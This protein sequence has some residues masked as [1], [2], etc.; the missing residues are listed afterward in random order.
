MEKKESKSNKWSDY[1]EE[2]YQECKLH[3][4]HSKVEKNV[5]I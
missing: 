4:R 1:E 2:V 5:K 3:Y